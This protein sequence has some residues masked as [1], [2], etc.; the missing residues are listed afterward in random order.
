MRTPWNRRIGGLFVAALC[1]A[2]AAAAQE[3]TPAADHDS[4]AAPQAFTLKGDTALWTVAIKSDKTADF[5]RVMTRLRDALAQSSE[6]R[7][8]EQAKGWKVI[9]VD[10][11]LPDGNIAYVHLVDPVVPGADYNIMQT[12]YEELPDERQA[13][14]E[15]YRGAFVQNLSLATGSVAVDL[16]LAAAAA[17]NK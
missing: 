12:L 6:P 1:C 7:R 11:P 8:Q 15:L 9:K 17:S 4:P 10:A 3:P 16:A 5:E 13:L 2:I 14:Y